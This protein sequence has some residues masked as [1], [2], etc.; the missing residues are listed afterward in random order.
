MSKHRRA[1]SRTL[2]TSRTPRP[3]STRTSSPTSRRVALAATFGLLTFAAGWVY[4]L[5]DNAVGTAS[6]A[7]ADSRPQAPDR[8]ARDAQREAPRAPLQGLTGISEQ[9]LARI[10]AESRQLVLVTGKAGDSSESTAALYT[11]PAAGADWVRTESWPARNGAKGWSTE[12]T[13]GDLTSP[14]G[15]FA[16]TDAGGLLA[17]PPGTRLPY[18]KDRAFVATGRGVNGE[19]LAGSFDYVVAIDFNRRP[20][21]SPL[22][23][24][25]P[26]G[27]DKG[28]NIWLH[29]DH[30]G[31]S[32]GCVGIPKEA[33][34]KVLATLDP[35]AKPVIVMGPEGF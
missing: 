10:P 6:Q 19:S 23:S 13:Y 1:R 18:D 12:R 34:K 32:Q 14:Q 17:P 5:D 33:M 20:G 27:E 3:G 15:V 35:A 29:V 28:G 4:A 24:V 2:R 21:K 8:A 11:R 7:R 30:D 9:T 22:D 25:K 16:L 31:P 26:E